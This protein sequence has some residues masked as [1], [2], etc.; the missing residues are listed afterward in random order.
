[1]FCLKY[2]KEEKPPSRFTQVSFYRN[3]KNTVASGELMH[4]WSDLG[5]IKLSPRL[6][7]KMTFLMS[8]MIARHKYIS[9]ALSWAQFVVEEDLQKLTAIALCLE[10]ASFCTFWLVLGDLIFDRVNELQIEKLCLG[11]K[12]DSILFPTSYLV[13]HLDTGKAFKS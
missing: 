9:N 6:V 13:P 12:L 3:V 1:M 7:G 4:L 2:A 11:W 5:K 8:Q 10:A